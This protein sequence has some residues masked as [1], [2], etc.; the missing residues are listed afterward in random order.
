VVKNWSEK[1]Y[2]RLPFFRKSIERPC[3]VRA[4]VTYFAPWILNPHNARA[5]I[6]KSMAKRNSAVN[7]PSNS[8]R[9]PPEMGWRVWFAL[10]ASCAASKYKKAP[11]YHAYGHDQDIN[12]H[13]CEACFGVAPFCNTIYRAHEGR[14]IQ[15][16]STWIY[17]KRIDKT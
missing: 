5:L 9:K 17:S 10:M 8:T 2:I 6:P 16:R 7:S 3:V 4:N 12:Q 14:V 15:S 11:H 13:S 1:N